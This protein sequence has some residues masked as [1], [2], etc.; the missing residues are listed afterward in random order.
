MQRDEIPP[1]GDLRP[2]RRD[3][4][5]PCRL[6]GEVYAF[7]RVG[8]ELVQLVGVGRAMNE[9]QVAAADHHDRRA[10]PFCHVLADH[11]AVVVDAFAEWQQR[12]ADEWL[13]RIVRRATGE[14]EDGG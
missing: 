9:L 11:R 10:R 6:G 7:V 1:L 2:Q 4:V 14:V 12:A 5:H 3:S 8:G 13:H